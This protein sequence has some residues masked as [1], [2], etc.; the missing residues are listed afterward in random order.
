[1]N[2]ILKNKKQINSFLEIITIDK[3]LL[4]NTKGFL[5]VDKHIFTAM[6]IIITINLKSY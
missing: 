3:V 1:M 5:H 2:F 4:S 6:K